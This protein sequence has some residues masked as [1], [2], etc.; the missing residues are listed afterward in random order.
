MV[1]WKNNT[2]PHQPL[3]WLVRV[4]LILFPQWFYA[5]STEIKI[6]GIAF[7]ILKEKDGFRT[8]K[9]INQILVEEH[10][11]QFA[12]LSKFLVD[13]KVIPK[14]YSFYITSKNK[15]NTIPL[16]FIVYDTEF[17]IL[18][19]A[20]LHYRKG[21]NEHT[22]QKLEL[23]KG[24]YYFGISYGIEELENPNAHIYE[25]KYYDKQ[26]KPKSKKYFGTHLGFL[27]QKKG[28]KSSYFFEDYQ[29][30]ERNDIAISHYLEYMEVHTPL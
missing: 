16:Y 27:S 24:E 23:K 19:K 20:P 22:I 1:K 5:Q 14:K 29:L 26:G 2:S 18:H 3:L 8:E 30:V 11:K 21:S 10:Q 25:F 4:F 6:E 15:R 13:K 12:A 17:N 7:T 9:N 28:G